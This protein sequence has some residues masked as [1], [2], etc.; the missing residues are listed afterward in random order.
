MRIVSTLVSNCIN[1]NENI[2][3]HEKRNSSLVTLTE[4]IDFLNTPRFR[5]NAVKPNI[6]NPKQ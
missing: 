4:T 3:G 6:A 2:R 5:K 1:I